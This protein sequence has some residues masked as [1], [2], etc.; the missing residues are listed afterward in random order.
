MPVISPSSAPVGLDTPT[1]DSDTVTGSTRGPVLAA[2]EHLGGMAVT[3][4]NVAKGSIGNNH[5]TRF[6]VWMTSHRGCT[7]TAAKHTLENSTA[8][9][10]VNGD[11]K[12]EHTAN[13][14]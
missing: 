6:H 13:V 2:Q 10:T 4:I 9:R 14:T 8:T 3:R 7:T 5:P 1:L 12:A 11:P